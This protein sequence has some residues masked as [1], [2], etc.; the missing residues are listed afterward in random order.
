VKLSKVIYLIFKNTKIHKIH[1]N[2]LGSLWFKA[3]RGF[4]NAE[5][6]RVFAELRRVFAERRVK[7][8]QE[9]IKLR[10]NRR[11]KQLQ[12]LNQKRIQRQLYFIFG[13]NGSF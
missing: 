12:Y 13:K 8:G 2:C 1:S 3:R 5:L 7:R 6:R 11:P 10:L 9:V 4:L